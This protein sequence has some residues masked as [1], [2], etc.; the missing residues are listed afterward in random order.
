M[1][2]PIPEIVACWQRAAAVMPPT[3][4]ANP[5]DPSVSLDTLAAIAHAKWGT[6]DALAAELERANEALRQI[7]AV[8]LNTRL[9]AEESYSRARYQMREIA[10]AA[11]AASREE[12]A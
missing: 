3:E 5:D 8:R 12:Q 7:V 6:A 11:L 4:P 2:E 1:S 9:P 10:L